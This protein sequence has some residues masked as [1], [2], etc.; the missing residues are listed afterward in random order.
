MIWKDGAKMS[1][2]KGNVVGIDEMVDKYGADTARAFILFVGPPE[3]D[4]EWSDR[5]VDGAHRFLIRV[6]RAA[7]DGPGFDLDWREHL[8]AEPDDSDR[9]LRRKTHQT[10]LKVTA[11]IADMGLNTMIS[12]MME[13]TN[14]V[15][16]YA[17]AAEGNPGK[18]AIYSE[19]VESLLLLL[20]PTAPHMC[21]ELWE[22][23]GHAPSVLEAGW[24]EAD[25]T[26]AAEE[27][28]EIAV[29]VS[30][31]VRDRLQ[32]PAGS[33]MSALVEQAMVLPGVARNLAGKQ[34]VKVITVPDKLINIVAK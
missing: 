3:Q 4:A 27:S 18:V 28:V 1:K 10:I 26:L 19:A 25:A 24:P 7:V 32:A 6:W 29:Q 22:R 12:G 17:D 20:S 14:E 31:K 13:L 2:S 8:P 5:G 15:L 33:D 23:T 16:P 9:A 34:V 21:E 11:D 30:G